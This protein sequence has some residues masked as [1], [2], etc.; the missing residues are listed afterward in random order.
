[1]SRLCTTIFWKSI[2]E[3]KI[4]NSH[5]QRTADETARQNILVKIYSMFNFIYKITL[6][7]YSA[8]LPLPNTYVQLMV[9]FDISTLGHS[10]SG[11][12]K[13][14][15]VLKRRVLTADTWS[16]R[17]DHTWWETMHLKKVHRIHHDVQPDSIRKPPP[18]PTVH[19]TFST[20]VAPNVPSASSPLPSPDHGSRTQLIPLRSQSQDN[21]LEPV[22]ITTKKHELL[23]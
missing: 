13:I 10:C 22:E 9:V 2:V 19:A 23:T 21:S 16:P 15:T 4:F 14:N 8:I 6:Y 5:Y 17:V 20:S 18:S 11:T 3:N 7:L 12:G 1:M